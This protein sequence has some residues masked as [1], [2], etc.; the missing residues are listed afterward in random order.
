MATTILTANSTAQGVVYSDAVENVDYIDIQ[1]ILSGAATGQR[2]Y[3]VQRKTANG[4]YRTATDPYGVPLQFTTTGA[5]QNGITLNALN[6]RYL[7]V[8]VEM[9]GACTGTVALE[10]EIVS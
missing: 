7:R 10:Y 3:T 1:A 8:K 4:A 2:V 9:L 6:A 5:E